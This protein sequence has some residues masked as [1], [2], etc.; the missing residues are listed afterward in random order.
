M[1]NYV[2]T[3]SPQVGGKTSRKLEGGCGGK[4]VTAY[5]KRWFKNSVAT[6]NKIAPLE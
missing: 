4:Y 3:V 6:I 2:P 5:Q 1:D